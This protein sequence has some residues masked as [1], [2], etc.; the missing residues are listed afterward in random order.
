MGDGIKTGGRPFS[1]T[2]E[3]SPLTK[4]LRTCQE[5]LKW[6]TSLWTFGFELGIAP[7]NNAAEPALRSA[8][9]W[10]RLSFGRQSEADSQFGA[11][12]LTVITTLKV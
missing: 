10:R 1:R 11:R 6:E 5:L 2:Q 7:T 4:T 9:I 3:Q 8:V 12:M